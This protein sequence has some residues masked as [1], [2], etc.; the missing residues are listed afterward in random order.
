M[1]PDPA[2]YPP[3]FNN[4]IKLVEGND[5]HEIIAK[6]TPAN[7]KFFESI[8]D[9]QSL[10]RY[11][12]EKWTVKEVLQH[13]I[14]TER[15]FCYRALALA[16]EERNTLPGF[17]EN[18]YGKRAHANNRKWTDLVEEFKAVRNATTFLINSFEETD[19]KKSGAVSDYQ[20]T[21][22]AISFIIAGHVLHHINI[23]RERYL[24]V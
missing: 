13:V 5:I 18:N 3:Y 15:I 11:D 20:I 7:L 12:D 10:Y 17:D 21:V 6:Q 9:D 8:S 1:R 24:E 2:T 19:F 23:I 22:G 4:Y 16:R 14:D